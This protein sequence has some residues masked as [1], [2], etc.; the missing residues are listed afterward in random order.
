MLRDTVRIWKN[1]LKTMMK[2]LGEKLKKRTSKLC[3]T[4]I[5]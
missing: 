1:I 2:S 4:S 3:W 5:I